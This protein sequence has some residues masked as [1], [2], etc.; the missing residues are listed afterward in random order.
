VVTMKI[1][2]FGDASLC[3]PVIFTQHF[4]GTC[5]HENG[6]SWFLSNMNKIFTRLHSITSQ[7]AEILKRSVCSPITW[8][9]SNGKTHV[10]E[11]IIWRKYQNHTCN[12]L[13]A[14]EAILNSEEWN[15]ECKIRCYT[16][17]F[18]Q[19]WKLQEINKNFLV[20][21]KK[22]LCISQYSQKKW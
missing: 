3:S 2:V 9:H 11:F 12:V 16:D 4:M 8:P 5:Y 1:A 20:R 15:Q 6:Y 21:R 17:A 13:H 10:T 22:G 19:L 7:M 14:L 18:Q